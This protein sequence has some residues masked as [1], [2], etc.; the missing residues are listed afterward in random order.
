MSDELRRQNIEA[1]L[2]ERRSYQTRLVEAEGDAKKALTD[3]VLAVNAS[4]T[5]LGYKLEPA[6][7]AAER[8][9]TVKTVSKKAPAKR[10][11]RKR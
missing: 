10:A 2:E 11:T 3:R 6:A 5:R 9:T 1:L 4:L 7:R 8:K